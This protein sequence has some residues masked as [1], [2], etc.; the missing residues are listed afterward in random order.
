MK[1]ILLACGMGASSGFLANAVRKAA[2]KQGLE[3]ECKAV[4][5]TDINTYAKDYDIIMLGPHIAYKL[6]EVKKLVENT[7]KKVLLVSKNAYAMLDG[8][9][10]LKDALKELENE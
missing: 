5:D 8:A 3:V 1:R 10:V 7:E 6:E 2:K 9:A 4:S